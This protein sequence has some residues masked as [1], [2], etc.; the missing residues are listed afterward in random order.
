MQKRILIAEDEPLGRR[1]LGAWLDRIGYEVALA[2]DGIE[3]LDLLDTSEFDLVISDLRMPRA[4]GVAVVSHL[5]SVSP[6]TP[7]IV[8]TAYPDEASTISRMPRAFYMKKPVLLEELESKI[9][10]LLELEL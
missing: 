9:R 6:E 8:L 4:D 3:A 7:F 2:K 10:F 1:Q 5:R